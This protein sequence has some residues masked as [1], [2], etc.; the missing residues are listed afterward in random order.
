MTAREQPASRDRPAFTF[1][2]ERLGEWAV[3]VTLA[4][5]AGLWLCWPQGPYGE[6]TPGRLPE[7][8]AA[9]VEVVLA[10]NPLTQHPD[11]LTHAADSGHSLVPARSLLPAIPAPPIAAAP[12]YAE[13]ASVPPAMPGLE[14]TSAWDPPPLLVRPPADPLPPV[15]VPPAR[16]VR[17]SPGLQAAQ[18]RLDQ[19]PVVSGGAARVVFQV[20]LNGDG[21]VTA[22]LDESGADPGQVRSW[23]QALLRGRGA[24]NGFGW[25]E[26]DW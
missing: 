19:P 8:G 4:L 16:R 9:Y 25:V 5:F 17:L 15:A 20:V 1:R 12:P 21:R 24:T 7:P 2:R 23:R 13:I 18:F 10:G 22:L 6:R 26:V 14:P 3:G 11:R